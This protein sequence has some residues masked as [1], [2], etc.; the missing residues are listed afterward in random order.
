[1]PEDLSNKCV[2]RHLLDYFM[3]P[4]VASQV[5]GSVESKFEKDVVDCITERGYRVRTQVPAGDQRSHRYR[6]DIVVEGMSGRLAVECDG[7]Q[8]HGPEQYGRDMARQRQLERSGWNFHRI[9]ASSFYLDREKTLN[10]LWEK[11]ESMGIRPERV[12]EIE[13]IKEKGVIERSETLCVDR[14]HKEIKMD[15]EVEINRTKILL[16]MNK[17]RHNAT[18]KNSEYTN[19]AQSYEDN[20]AQEKES[21]QKNSDGAREAKSITEKSNEEYGVNSV[22]EIAPEVWFAIS[23]WA[24]ENDHFMGWER[25][26]LYS[27]GKRLRQGIPPSEKQAKHASRLYSLAINNGF[28]KE[29]EVYKKVKRK[30]GKKH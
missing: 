3:N 2:R 11:L 12:N 16:D 29:K 23:R 28:V 17:Q 15:S 14:E 9:R 30:R 20:A 4:S 8:W 7:D 19:A 24:K 1:M 22:S 6:I 10:Y 25:G 13:R 18:K 5:W 26:V 21:I 27:V